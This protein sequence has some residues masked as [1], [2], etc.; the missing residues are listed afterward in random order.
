M[1]VGLLAA[2]HECAGTAV[3]SCTGKP[4]RRRSEL[5]GRLPQR[6]QRSYVTVSMSSSYAVLRWQRLHD[7]NGFGECCSGAIPTSTPICRTRCN[8][9]TFDRCFSR[10]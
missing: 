10:L 8:S 6:M 7:T 4:Q 9:M 2:M 1:A 3:G 5:V